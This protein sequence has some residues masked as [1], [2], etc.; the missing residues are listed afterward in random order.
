LIV[1][2]QRSGTPRQLAVSF[3]ATAAAA[4]A[5]HWL[6]SA[7][8]ELKTQPLKTSGNRRLMDTSST[9]RRIE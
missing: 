6:A 5:A 2:V 8:A 7:A 1:L 4:T 3:A 9:P